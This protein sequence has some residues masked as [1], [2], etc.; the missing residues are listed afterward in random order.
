M[1]HHFCSIAKNRWFLI[2]SGGGITIKAKKIN[3]AL[4]RGVGGEYLSMLPTDEVHPLNH[5]ENI[6]K[7]S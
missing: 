4:A 5:E 2:H 6:Q 3:H 7:T 1:T